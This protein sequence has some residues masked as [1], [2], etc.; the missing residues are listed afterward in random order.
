MPVDVDIQMDMHR[1]ARYIGRLARQLPFAAAQAINKT[2]LDAQKVQRAHQERVFEVRNKRFV[3]RAVKIKPFA[4]KRKLEARMLIDPPGGRERASVL[5]QHERGGRKRPR[6]G[7]HLTIPVDV[8]RTRRGVVSRTLRPRALRF[9]RVGRSIR[10]EKRTFI[11][12]GQGIFQR[13]GRGRRS[14]VR[15][16]YAFKRA[17]PIAPSLQF[18]ENA[19]R[20][21]KERFHPNFRT[22]FAEAKRTAR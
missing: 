15:M 7:Q 1:A 18:I 14:R 12:P 21:V 19:R 13:L 16:L 9:R 11:I 10:G 20:T 4:T 8:R 6:D 17:V 22:A 2:A 3:E 5:T